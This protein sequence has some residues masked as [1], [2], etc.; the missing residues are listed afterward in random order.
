MLTE[1]YRPK[2]FEDIIGQKEIVDSI[3]ELVKSKNIPYMLFD[4]PPGC[5]KKTLSWIVARERFPE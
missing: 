1:K 4:G 3:S 2:K 5:G